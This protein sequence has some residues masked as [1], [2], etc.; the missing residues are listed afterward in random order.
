MFRNFMYRSCNNGVDLL[1][2][3]SPGKFSGV[4]MGKERQ[5]TDYQVLP[6]FV[7][8]TNLTIELIA[9][10]EN[11]YTTTAELYVEPNPENSKPVSELKLNYEYLQV[12]E[13]YIHKTRLS[14][15]QYKIEEGVLTIK[16]VPQDVNFRIT[17]KNKIYRHTDLFGLYQTDNTL[18]IKAE[19]EGMRRVFPCIDRPDNLSTYETTIIAPKDKYPMLIANGAQVE[20]RNLSNGMH[21]VKWVNS[22]PIPTYL[23]ALVA[24][25]YH[26]VHCLPVKN[27]QKDMQLQF[28]LPQEEDIQNCAIAESTLKKALAFDKRVFN[29]DCTLD[30]YSI[31]GIARYASAASE[32]LGLNLY[33]RDYL[34]GTLSTRTANELN[35]ILEVVSHETFHNTTGNPHDGFTIRDF[36]QLCL[37]E[38]LTTLKSSLFL[39]EELGVD[40]DRLKEHGIFTPDAPRPTSYTNVR[41]LYTGAAYEKSAEIFRMIRNKMNKELFAETLSKFTRENRGKAIT[42]EDFFRYFDAAFPGNNLFDYKSWFDEDGIPILTVTEDYN[43]KKQEYV[44]N[45]EVENRHGRP[46][47]VAIA[48]YN[49]KGDPITTSEIHEL[50]ADKQSVPFKGI[51][52]R[53]TPSLLRNLSAPVQIN[54]AYNLR[55]LLTLWEHDKDDYTR[56]KAAKEL[57]SRMVSAYCSG[58]KTLNNDFKNT[59]SILLRR[60]A[61]KP[62][63]M[64]VANEL[65]KF[66]SEE[67]LCAQLPQYEYEDIR[68]ARRELMSKISTHLNNELKDLVQSLNET[69]QKKSNDTHYDAYKA[70]ATHLKASCFE[71]LV[72]T[73]T[74]LRHKLRDICKS[75]M[76]KDMTVVYTALQT[77]INS[78][79]EFVPELLNSFYTHYRADQQALNYWFQLQAGAKNDS[80]VSEVSKLLLHEQ[81]DEQNPSQV[82]AL[83]GT[84]INNPV[85]LHK[86]D[87]SGYQLLADFILKIEPKNPTFAARLA[88]R[89]N[90]TQLAQKEQMITVLKK[91]EKSATMDDVRLMVKK[92]LGETNKPAVSP[93]DEKCESVGNFSIFAPQFPPGY[94]KNTK[95]Q[96]SDSINKFRVFAGL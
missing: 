93:K 2:L 12:E 81:F 28:L 87:G 23:F 14:P 20:A 17:T 18:L 32:T 68:T 5:I 84:F 40:I 62:M 4:I 37:K 42:L 67:V 73:S 25:T 50:R 34:Y 52:C 19:T 24:G 44:L 91:L 92:I 65:L 80:V 38:G 46:I 70:G 59:Y 63:N 55:Q 48:L 74:K 79:D 82:N 56:I 31:V 54:Y 53:P 11:A 7:K 85:G 88:S 15:N 3:L 69:L 10:K 76:N 43:E 61:T 89:F 26:S 72:T 6:F 71:F 86:K 60:Q 1:S 51:D 64:W 39:E 8:H 49:S 35:R 41:N 83:L 33:A 36:F 77:L 22:S 57:Y 90:Y 21:L 78:N 29:L 94:G 45:F 75:N 27:S 96:L 30:N 9:N 95:I 66:P 47:P 16:N 13:V 58:D